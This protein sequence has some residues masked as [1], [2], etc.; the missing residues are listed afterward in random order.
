MTQAWLCR[1]VSGVRHAATLAA[2]APHSW[3]SCRNAMVYSSSQSW[4]AGKEWLRPERLLC[5][6]SQVA[7]QV[8]AK[9]QEDHFGH[10][11]GCRIKDEKGANSSGASCGH[12]NTL[13]EAV[14]RAHRCSLLAH[15]LCK[16]ACMTCLMLPRALLLRNCAC[17][18][19]VA[20]PFMW[21]ALLQ[22]CT[23][24]RD[25]AHAHR[26]LEREVRMKSEFASELVC[27]QICQSARLWRCLFLP[28]RACAAASTRQWQSL[29]MAVQKLTWKVRVLPV[30]SAL[31][32]RETLTPFT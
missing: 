18:C 14:W 15:S 29:R 21:H 11:D 10:E 9:H 12:A 1:G 8:S 27:A 28:I 24:L 32:W 19:A 2:G 5:A 17:A 31:S 16:Q 23:R 26:S 13:Y 4:L 6:C 30:L 7:N 3:V 25:C 22:V 20:P